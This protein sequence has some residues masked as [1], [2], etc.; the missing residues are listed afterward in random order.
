MC[1]RRRG[2]SRSRAPQWNPSYKQIP[3]TNDA[4]TGKLLFHG[5]S[6]WE[7]PFFR[8][9]QELLSRGQAVLVSAESHGEL[10][11]PP[12][13]Q[14]C[15]PCLTYCARLPKHSLTAPLL[16]STPP[17]AQGI[18]ACEFGLLA[19]VPGGAVELD[20]GGRPHL[21]MRGRHSKRSFPFLG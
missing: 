13:G 11:P 1:T 20:A 15:P 19:P 21:G 7:A 9:A 6:S 14:A 16:P 12:R 17:R 8:E 2:A 10:V 3:F 18:Q 4:V 5:G